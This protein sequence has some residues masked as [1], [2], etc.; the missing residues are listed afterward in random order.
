MVLNVKGDVSHPR[1]A[2]WEPPGVVAWVGLDTP[3]PDVKHDG[4]SS[5][6]HLEEFQHENCE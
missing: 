4:K 6:W 5:H 1:L 2:V 3:V